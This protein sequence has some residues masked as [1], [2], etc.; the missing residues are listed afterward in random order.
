[1]RHIRL[2]ALL[3]PLLAA[4]AAQSDD[5]AA[6][7]ASPP[8]SAAASAAGS[9]PDVAAAGMCSNLTIVAQ[10]PIDIAAPVADAS[11]PR[12]QLAYVPSP[13]KLFNTGSS[14][15]VNLSRRDTLR[16]SGV[17]YAAEEF[18]FH[19]P[20]EHE[21]DTDSF[22]AE[23]HIVHK[24]PGGA[25]ALGTFVQEGAHNAAWDEIWR[26]L[27]RPGADTVSLAAV[28]LHRLFGLTPSLDGEM[29]YR[30][31]GS[32][33]TPP[34]D[35][36]INWLVRAE[37]IEMSAAQLDSLRLVMGEYSRDLQDLN[38]RVVRYRQP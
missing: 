34:Y 26:Q 23:I 4:C 6:A 2:A 28:G 27:P 11:L 1:M 10:S 17:G 38:G 25:V 15:Q 29:V 36:G 12:V 14:V 5:D 37:P 32:L 19:W 35:E 22:P 9:E 20:G 31:C 33:T 7:G 24:R 16:I 13:G 21:L 8:D 3:L 30:Y 18:H